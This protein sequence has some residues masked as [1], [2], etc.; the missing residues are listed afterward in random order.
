MNSEHLRIRKLQQNEAIK[1]FDCGDQD[2]NE[3]IVDEAP[4]YRTALLAVTY[5]LE[6]TETGE[7]LAYFS[8]AN[9]RVSLSDFESRTEFNKFRKKRFVNE[10]RIKSYPA[11]KLCRLAVN[12]SAR[13]MHIGSYLIDF[14]KAFFLIDNKTGCRFITVDAYRSAIPFY[15]RNGFLPLIATDDDEM[16]RLL[17]FDL[18]DYQESFND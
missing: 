7:T 4:Y 13:E 6:S 9:D 17:Y 5:V 14:I 1:S 15:E 10:K 16:T 8:L 2:L 3:F 18:A 11:A 12:L